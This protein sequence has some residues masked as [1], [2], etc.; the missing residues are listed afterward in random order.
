MSQIIILLVIVVIVIAG[1][2][3]REISNQK[4]GKDPSL[5]STAEQCTKILIKTQDPEI[6]RGVLFQRAE[7]YKDDGNYQNAIDDY[8]K[9]IELLPEYEE[10]LFDECYAALAYSYSMLGQYDAAISYAQKY[11]DE[12]ELA[13][14]YI[15][16]ADSTENIE[17]AKPYYEKAI[18]LLTK[19]IARRDAECDIYKQADDFETRA[20]CYFN[21]QE[22]ANALDDINKAIELYEEYFAQ[23]K[24]CSSTANGGTL[25]DL[26]VTKQQCH[27]A[28]GQYQEALEACDKVLEFG[29]YPI[30]YY[31]KAA[32][33]EK[34]NRTDE[35][36]DFYEKSKEMFELSIKQNPH[37]KD[38]IE[39]AKENIQACKD[40]IQSLKG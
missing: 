5:I 37:D 32:L 38:S 3:F 23:N 30:D 10:Q 12:R 16:K 19:D 13:S 11:A 29:E 33:L 40:K 17:D 1:L 14:Y 9:V 34:L 26:Y 39:F 24:D 15:Q 35:A 18:E 36:I 7:L 21:M 2:L 27:Y 28:L 4:T 6:A 8:L 22:K 31:N 20:N 25:G